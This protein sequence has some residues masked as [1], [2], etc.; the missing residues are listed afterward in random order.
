MGAGY[1]HWVIT[2]Y[3]T[4]FALCL[5]FFF[6]FLSPGSAPPFFRCVCHFRVIRRRFH[7]SECG[8]RAI[9]RTLF[10]RI[11]VRVLYTTSAKQQSLAEVELAL[12]PVSNET[13]GAGRRKH[14][15]V[16]LQDPRLTARSHDSIYSDFHTIGCVLDCVSLRSRPCD[17]LSFQFV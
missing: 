7:L 9:P 2:P 5:S 13:L 8:G 1:S 14:Y 15:T 17:T 6:F 16:A 3:S 10:R 11:A 4:Y 12:D